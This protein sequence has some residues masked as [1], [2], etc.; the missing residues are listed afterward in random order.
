M[1]G[2][3]MSSIP[4]CTLA[5]CSIQAL[6]RFCNA[7]TQLQLAR[8]LRARRRPTG[9]IH[10]I[11]DRGLVRSSARH[12]LC[13]LLGQI[14]SLISLSLVHTEDELFPRQPVCNRCPC[15]AWL[16]FHSPITIV[17]FVP[18]V[19]FLKRGTAGEPTGKVH[20]NSA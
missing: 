12:G 3:A 11:P 1:I 14:W 20:G 16:N 15:V 4:S 2:L 19:R 5:N 7:V 10:S 6:W 9:S 8:A 18:G 17:F 13:R